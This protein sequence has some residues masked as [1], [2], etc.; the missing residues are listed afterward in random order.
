MKLQPE[1]SGVRMN[2]SKDVDLAGHADPKLVMTDSDLKIS[3]A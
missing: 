3:S 2:P 1:E